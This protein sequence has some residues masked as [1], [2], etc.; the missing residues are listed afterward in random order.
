MSYDSYLMISL[1]RD[2]AQSHDV[3]SKP[4]EWH[5]VRPPEKL[6]VL[7]VQQSKIAPFNWQCSKNF[8]RLRSQSMRL[9]DFFLCRLSLF[10]VSP[11]GD[12][13]STAGRPFI[14]KATR[15]LVTSV[16]PIMKSL[17]TSSV[18]SPTPWILRSVSIYRYDLV[19]YLLFDSY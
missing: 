14:C 5:S 1:P 9:L 2:L 17:S 15:L 18:R 6:R 13:R 8:V 4:I 11:R 3:I 16:R 7:T 19:L 10:V 12:L